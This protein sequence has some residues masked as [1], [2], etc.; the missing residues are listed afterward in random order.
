MTS[1]ILNYQ[2]RVDSLGQDEWSRLLTEFSDASIYQTW[3][4]AAVHG[5][6]SSFSHCV[7]ENEGLAV[8][9]AQVRLVRPFL[10]PTGLAQ[11]F[12]GPMWRRTAG[13]ADEDGLAALIRAM[14]EE[15]V[16]RR[17]YVLRVVPNAFEGTEEGDLIHRLLEAEGFKRSS[18]SRVYRT[19]RLDLT[20]PL[21]ELRRNLLQKWRNQLNRAER[22]GL[23]VDA[24]H[25]VETYDLFASLYQA[26]MERKQFD[27]DVSVSEFREIQRGLTGPLRMK[28][29]VSSVEGAVGCAVVVSA[30][31]DS[32]IYLL[33]ATNE[34][35]MKSKGSYLLHWKVIQWL[36]E[37]GCQWYDLGGINPDTNPGVFHFKKGFSGLDIRQVGRYELAGSSFS[38][39]VVQMGERLRDS[40]RKRK[41]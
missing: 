14:K 24:G 32:G 34:D 4:Y 20:P 23:V 27:T 33:G 9:A 18:K 39:F 5:R 10:F 25:D 7:V 17:R 13:G 35:G 22:N 1:S 19:F 37:M 31:G 38:R 12:W 36:K 2:V 26:M 6:N 41:S 40:I 29:F 3:V 30:I 28:T 11:V 16:E 15:Y 21:D 8:A